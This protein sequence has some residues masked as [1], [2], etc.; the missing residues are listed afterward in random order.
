MSQNT[1]T[2]ST[3]WSL[4]Q[5]V[6]IEQLHSSPQG[7]SNEEAQERLSQFGRNVLVSREKVTPVW[8]FLN[9]FKSPLI[10][11]L[12]FAA[13]I[14]MLT[15]EWVDATVIL[16]ILFASAVMGFTQEYR[17]NNAMEKLRRQV[18]ITTKVL[19]DGSPRNIPA[20]E[21]V[22]G[23]VVVLSAGS[24]IPA[25]GIVIQADD[26]FVNQAVLTG[27][28]F[29]VEKKPGL[30]PDNASLAER[31]NC[32]FMGTNVRSGSARAL[33]F[34]TGKQTAYGQIADRLAVP[35]PETE[36]Q[37]GIRQFGEMLTKVMMA[38]VLVVFAMN[39]YLNKPVIDALMFSVALA[40]GIAPEMLPVIINITLSIG[41]QEMAKRGVIV[42]KLEAIENFGSMDVLCTDKTGTLTM[43]VVHLD[44]ALDP[45]GQPSEEVFRLAYLNA[46][47][48][49]GL[50]NP[51]DEAILA[52]TTPEIEPFVKT[53][54][55]P[56]DFVRKRLSI[57]VR[58]TALSG[59]TYTMITKGALDKVLEACTT[60]QSDGRSAPLDATCLDL[61]QKRFDQWSDQG[62][63][64]LGIATKEVSP[65]A[66]YPVEAE[67]DMTFAGFLLFFDPPKPDTQ[68]TI[69]DLRN[70]GVQL[71][72]IT[73]DN[74]LVTQHIAQETGMQASEVITG[75]DLNQMNDEALWRRADEVNLFAEV[76]PNQKERIISA[77]RKTGHVVGYM[78]DGINDAPA[79]H[80]ADVGIS[81][82]NAVD[83]AKEAADFVLLEQSL[84][85][86]RR[87]IE[88]GRKT[89]A[90]T[91]KYISFTESA[92]FGN[93]V[94]MAILSPFLPFL[95]LLPKQIL[96]N[97]FLSD[98]PAMTIATDAVD[99]E[100]VSKPERWNIDFIR[101]FMVVFGSLS[102]LFDF[103]TFGLLLCVLKLTVDQF[104]TGWFI[105]SLL[106][107]L[108][109]FLV[110]RTRRPF[111]RSRPGRWLLL[112]T[113]LVS[114]I[115]LALPYLP[116][117]Q[118]I[119]GFVPLSPLLMLLLMGITLLYVLANEVTKKY[120]YHR[121]S[122]GKG[123]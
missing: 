52:E 12:V 88:E 25:D 69:Q 45:E 77:L 112:S 114:L 91:L 29:P 80:A 120:F 49:T 17:A 46:Q 72:L 20:E 104:R 119:F 65:Q 50:T 4:P 116:F 64:V 63:R 10:L 3:Q 61:I 97:N 66:E 13:F 31:T 87:G 86:L 8:L 85:V 122:D 7:L 40:V 81:V 115:S 76:D 5:E 38:L 73:G 58:D 21:V 6:L 82:N 109:A 27:E 15:G 92:N 89:F 75:S 56:Y 26:F 11:I 9:Q 36:F 70:F 48:Q 68:Q 54:E 53:E 37:R 67:F 62:Y 28:S 34:Q 96:L 16:T 79:L 101:N 32:V 18:T 95:P 41:A 33:I 60:M 51:L 14:A 39:V 84:D 47:F 71:K 57:V 42:R 121:T 111:L 113:L 24:I 1:E 78:G 117:M 83:V 107:E 35:P 19:R 98:I 123:I 59:Q 110:V 94:S 30:V 2:T 44:G 106:T 105:E 43:G 74:R 100:M 90:N 23:D 93:M 22:P 55:I 99:P 103:L 102:S 118:T 108:F